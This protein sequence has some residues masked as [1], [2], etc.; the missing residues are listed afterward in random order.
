[1]AS[2]ETQH[3]QDLLLITAAAFL[4]S[5]AISMLAVLIGLYLTKRHASAAEVG[6]IVTAGLAGSTV[7][8]LLVTVV[9]DRLNKR[10]LL[11]SIACLSALG[12]AVVAQSERFEILLLASFF[13]MLN[14]MGRDR[15]AALVIEQALLPAT[16]TDKRRTLAFAWYNVLQDIGHGLGSLLAALPFVLEKSFALEPL[17]SFKS[18]ILTAGA[19]FGL[20]GIVYLFMSRIPFLTTVA[21]PVWRLSGETKSR[22]T[23]I[24]TLFAIDS[25]AGGFI[26]T[27][28]ISIFFVQRFGVSIEALALLFFAYRVCNAISHLGAAWLAKKIG[29]LNTMVF[30]HIP[31][32]LLL[33]TVAIAPSFEVAALLFLLREG[34]VE[35]D[36]PTRQ[37]YVMA[38]VSPQ[39]RT[40]ASGITHLVRMAGWSVP[41][42][43]A[44][45]SMQ[46]ISLLTPLLVAAAMK[47]TYD[48][49]LYVSFKQI[50]PPEEVNK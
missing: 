25:L 12:C 35:M 37:S 20:S 5:A 42:L 23:R 8:I 40:L 22:I 15:G 50:K 14:G 26:T 47:I 2:P 6:A 33:V 31:S 44:G 18:S 9:G 7:A 34:L 48:I 27:A 41:P 24:S 10:F 11:F 21:A 3:K 28:L 36:V 39:E 32:S 4:R 46:S 19:I 43:F 49:L 45:L 30:T 17:L 38:I 1:M 16:T 13:G 29:L